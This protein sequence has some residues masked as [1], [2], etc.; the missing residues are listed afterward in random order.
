MPLAADDKG[1]NPDDSRNEK[2]AWRRIGTC[3]IESRF[4]RM[5]RMYQGCC[6]MRDIFKSHD[7]S[8]VRAV[9]FSKDEGDAFCRADI[10]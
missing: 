5:C 6:R 10:F 2:A 3:A 9:A 1:T 7:Q 4:S 8:P